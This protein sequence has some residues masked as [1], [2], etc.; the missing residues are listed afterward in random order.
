MEKDDFEIDYKQLS[1]DTG[2]MLKNVWQQ[3][4]L[5]FELLRRITENGD[6]VGAVARNILK[7]NMTDQIKYLKVVTWLIEVCTKLNE[8]CGFDDATEEENDKL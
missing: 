4:N 1:E 5:Y 8:K 3:Q 7:M 2:K 6:V